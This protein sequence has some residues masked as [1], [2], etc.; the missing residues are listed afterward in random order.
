M[1]CHPQAPSPP[2]PVWLSVWR[3]WWRPR[4]QLRNGGRWYP[5]GG[6][7]VTVRPPRPLWP[8]SLG[9]FMIGLVR[10]SLLLLLE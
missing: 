2:V 4:L 5:H 10:I 6:P 7:A 8:S 3:L 1:G 9:E